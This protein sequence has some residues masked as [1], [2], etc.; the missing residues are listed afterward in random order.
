MRGSIGV[1]WVVAHAVGGQNSTGKLVLVRRTQDKRTRDLAVFL[2][3]FMSMFTQR[4][5]TRKREELKTTGASF[6]GEEGAA[7]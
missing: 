1:L 7:R 4:R 5:A 6:T 2:F 3:G